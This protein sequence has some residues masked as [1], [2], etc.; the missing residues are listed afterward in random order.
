[1]IAVKM[2]EPAAWLRDYAL[3]QSALLF[4]VAAQA[5]IVLL[6]SY[7]AVRAKAPMAVDTP[8]ASISWRSRR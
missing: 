3:A 7:V 2:S 6:L 4:T 8:A 5:P 1:M